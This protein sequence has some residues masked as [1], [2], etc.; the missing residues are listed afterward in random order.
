ME[1]LLDQVGPPAIAVL[2]P[3][4]VALI[5]QIAAF[6]PKWS[7]PIIAGALGPAI[8]QLLALLPTIDAV[9]SQSVLLGLAGIG[10]REVVDQTR[11]ARAG[12]TS[13][14]KGA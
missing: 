3:L 12:P 13:T 7:L 14:K 2:V 4:V 9:G 8:D 10:I 11:K 1:Q 6:L 5:R